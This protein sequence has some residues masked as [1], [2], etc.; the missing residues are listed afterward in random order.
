MFGLALL[1]EREWENYHGSKKCD[2]AIVSKDDEEDQLVVSVW[3]VTRVQ[4]K[5]IKMH[6]MSLL[7]KSWTK[8]TF[9]NPLEIILIKPCM[10]LLSSKK[11]QNKW[12]CFSLSDQKEWQ[13][14]RLRVFWSQRELQELNS[15]STMTFISI[16]FSFQVSFAF[17]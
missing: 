17:N 16:L 5:K 11:T 15:Y 3:P 1:L 10:N 4:T 9:K 7:K 6:L 12:F 2:E 14:W 13:K 8:E